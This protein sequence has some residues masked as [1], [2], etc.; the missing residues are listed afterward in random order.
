MSTRQEIKTRVIKNIR[1][2]V[3]NT[4]I[5]IGDIERAAGIS[6]GY[7]SRKEAE[8]DKEASEG[9]S[10]HF[11]YVFAKKLGIEMDILTDY[12]IYIGMENI[13]RGGRALQDIHKIIMDILDLESQVDNAQV[14]EYLESA[15]S[16]LSR[17]RHV[18]DYQISTLDTTLPESV[19]KKLLEIFS[20]VS[21]P[22]QMSQSA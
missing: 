17:A 19:V 7:L 21:Q 6:I 2:L 9:I 18:Q 22:M 11:L 12:D 10:L 5:K 20:T 13:L 14:Q 15:V 1:Y 8:I 4:G 3:D 16:T